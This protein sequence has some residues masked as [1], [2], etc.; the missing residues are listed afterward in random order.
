[1]QADDAFDFSVVPVV[2]SDNPIRKKKQHKDK[3]VEDSEL[4]AAVKDDTANGGSGGDSSTKSRKR[5]KDAPTT[6]NAATTTFTTTTTTTT[7]SKKQRVKKG[8]HGIWV[9]NLAFQ[10]TESA[11]RDLFTS[12]CGG[13]ITRINLPVDKKGRNKGFV[14]VDFD[15]DETLQKALQL[16]ETEL[17]GRALLVKNAT[18]FDTTGRLPRGGRSK[19]EESQT[20]TNNNYNN[21]SSSSSSNSGNNRG[22]KIFIGNLPLETEREDLENLFSRY[23]Q[24]VHL[25]M[26]AFEDSQKC[27]GYAHLEFQSPLQAQSAVKA[28]A[29]KLKGKILRVEFGAMQQRP[30]RKKLH[31]KA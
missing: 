28:P 29:L 31:T 9:G 30:Q 24:I 23:G 25:R 5:K 27:K 13:E 4:M 8:A 17:D 20:D 18:S 15:S 14:Y 21:N 11:I 22:N 10:T 6:D 1:M 26:A 19:T 12:K 3:R 16:T 7:S 2:E